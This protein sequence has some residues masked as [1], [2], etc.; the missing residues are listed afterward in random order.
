MFQAYFKFSEAT[1]FPD[2]AVTRDA[3]ISAS[4]DVEADEVVASALR[5]LGKK[6][7]IYERI[8]CKY[9]TLLLQ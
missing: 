6:T 4:L 1:L 5:S 2:G 8:F 9:S 7:S 3:V